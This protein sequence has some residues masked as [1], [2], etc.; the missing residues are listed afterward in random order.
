M[1]GE[2]RDLESNG[3]AAITSNIC[4]TFVFLPKNGQNYTCSKCKLITLLEEKVQRLE[5][6]QPH[7]ELSGKMRKFSLDP[8]GL[9]W[10]RD[11]GREH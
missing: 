6:C 8:S 1:C 2:P 4:A 5:A 11:A 9:S 7:S 3:A 10:S